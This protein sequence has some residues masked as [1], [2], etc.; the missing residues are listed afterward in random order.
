MFKTCAI[1][2]ITL[3]KGVYKSY[4]PATIWVHLQRTLMT[5][6]R[7]KFISPEPHRQLVCP[8]VPLAHQHPH[9]TGLSL[10]WCYIPTYWHCPPVITSLSQLGIKLS[11]CHIYDPH[12]YHRFRLPQLLY[13]RICTLQDRSWIMEFLIWFVVI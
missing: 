2:S 8:P 5:R 1:T 6:H 9:P 4:Y 13:S 7:S 10:Y 11:S 3:W 12:S